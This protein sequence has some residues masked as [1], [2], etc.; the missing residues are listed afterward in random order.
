MKIL[1]EVFDPATNF[2]VVAG[3]GAR[4]VPGDEGQCGDGGPA[5]LARLSHPKGLAVTP[6]GG[7]FIADGRNLRYIHQNGE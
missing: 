7:L 1:D 6:D 4:C 5:S 2:E 3:G